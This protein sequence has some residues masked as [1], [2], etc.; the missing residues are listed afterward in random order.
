[1]TDIS[2]REKIARIIHP[3]AWFPPPGLDVLQSGKTQE[4]IDAEVKD[5]QDTA[6]MTADRLIAAGYK[7]MPVDQDKDARIRE[8]EAWQ[9]LVFEIYGNIDLDIER[10]KNAK[11]PTN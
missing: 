4:Q 7:S 6:L 3:G 2:E 11:S 8:L 5:S 10:L 9:E 1:M